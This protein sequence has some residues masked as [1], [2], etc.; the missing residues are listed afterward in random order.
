MY[1]LE[2]ENDASL[3]KRSY[4]SRFSPFDSIRLITHEI[5]LAELE[6]LGSVRNFICNF[7]T[8]GFNHVAFKKV[9]L[10][11][12]RGFL[13]VLQYRVLGPLIFNIYVNELRIKINS[14][15]VQYSDET[16]LFSCKKVQ[17]SFEILEKEFQ[18]LL[19][20]LIAIFRSSMQTKRITMFYVSRNL[21]SVNYS[22][23]TKD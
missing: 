17:E 15:I 12:Y 10:D 14:N 4:S 2:K 8:D 6:S 1:I 9:A 16:V 22:W 5:F 23:W 19:I 11:W 18:I 13:G 7:P 3:T 21:R 20:T